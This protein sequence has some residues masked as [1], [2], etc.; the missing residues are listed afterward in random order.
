M[1]FVVLD[2]QFVAQANALVENAKSSID[3][4][5]FKAEITSK[6]RGL[7]LLGFFEKLMQKAK[8]GVRIRVLLNWNQ[9]RKSVAKTN[10]FVMR[11]LKENNIK[12]RHLRNNRCCHAKIILVDKKT[13]LLGS[14]NLSVKSVGSNFELSYLIPDPESIN[15]LSS[16]FDHTFNDAQKF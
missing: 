10:L 3:I 12:V 2:N 1:G 16:V 6:T 11:K 9:D 5:T 13:A 4:S 7:V 8:Q 15:Q 14:H